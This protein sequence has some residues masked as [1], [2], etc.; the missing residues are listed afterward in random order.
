MT[1]FV[2][3]VGVD[4]R[5]ASSINFATDSRISWGVSGKTHWDMARKTFSSSSS[6]DIFGYVNDVMFPSMILGQIVNAIDS[7]GIFGKDDTCGVRFDK[8]VNHIKNSHELYPSKMR[9]SFCIFHGSR[10]G[11]GLASVFGLNTIAW[12]KKT[13]KWTIDQLTIPE[14]SSAI[15]IDG[16]GKSI[17]SKWSERWSSSSQGG[18]SRAVFSSFC[19]AVHSGEDRLTNGAPQIVSLYRKDSGKTIG[20]VGAGKR[21]ISGIEVLSSADML[22]EKVEWRNRYFERCDISGGLIS[23]AQKHHVPK[24]LT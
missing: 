16:S 9:E 1:T 2:A 7:G 5:V 10:E 17:V 21:F 8:V 12:D 14:V 11:T 13:S 15:T 3:W 18:T 6:P 22:D 19:N 4:S 20:F 24:G 23:G